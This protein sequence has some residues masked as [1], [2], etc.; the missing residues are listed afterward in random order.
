MPKGQGER[1]RHL[2]RP[3]PACA[4]RPWGPLAAAC[5][6][7]PARP[8]GRQALGRRT[9]PALR[10]E[11]A[12]GTTTTVGTTWAGRRPERKAAGKGEGLDCG[13]CRT[14]QCSMQAHPWPICRR[15]VRRLALRGG[16]PHPPTGHD[17]ASPETD[18]DRHGGVGWGGVGSFLRRQRAAACAL[19]VCRR[20]I[21]PAGTDRQGLPARKPRMA[22]LILISA[23]ALPCR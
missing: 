2:L 15:V 10:G 23:F 11:K 1:A 17:P 20:R 12:A 21:A 16:T 8:K 5:T 4:A 22:L 6:G 14:D 7:M 13:C 3:C 18:R 9:R 19:A